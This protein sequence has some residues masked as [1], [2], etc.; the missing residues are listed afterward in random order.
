MTPTEI[1]VVSLLRGKDLGL[2]ILEAGVW[3]TDKIMQ[4]K[5]LF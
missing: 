3:R 2:G 1:L 4:E 5:L